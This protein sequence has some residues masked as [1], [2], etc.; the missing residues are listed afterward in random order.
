MDTD[1][2]SEEEELETGTPEKGQKEK[3]TPHPGLTTGTDI[4]DH[5]KPDGKQVEI[6]LSKVRI[7]QEKT[8]GPIRRKDAKLL[9][10]RI[11][12]LQAAPPTRPIHV[13]FWEKVC[14]Q[15]NQTFF[16]LR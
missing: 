16:S 7:D 13:V 9:L 4:E 11:E 1:Y 5:L 2:D 15:P 12:S 10:K 14:F 3:E 8:K 6:E